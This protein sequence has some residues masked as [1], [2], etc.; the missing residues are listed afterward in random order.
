V[1][2][3]IFSL[4]VVVA[5]GHDIEEVESKVEEVIAD[6]VKNGVSE[7]DLLR[8]KK[9]LKAETIYAQ[10]DLKTLA[11]VYGEVLTAGLPSSYVDDWY[12][13]IEV[14]GVDDV[15]AAAELVLQG[16]R[17]VTGVLVKEEK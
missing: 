4:R 1:G 10:E 14:V 13:N 7:E 16:G 8:V 12:G 2:P 15:V 6:V 5:P 11:Y 9:V 17:S 3:S